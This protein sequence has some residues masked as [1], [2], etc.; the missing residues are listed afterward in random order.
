M[1]DEGHLADELVGA[2]VGQEHA[3]C[4]DPCTTLDDVERIPATGSLG[5]D[6]ASC[7]DG[8]ERPEAV[9]R[10]L[11]RFPWGARNQLGHGVLSR[12]GLLRALC[13]SAVANRL[14]GRP[15]QGPGV[16][17]NRRPVDVHLRLLGRL[18][19]WD[20]TAVRKIGGTKERTLLTLLAL[21][22]GRAV[23]VDAIADAL[24][25]DDPP[26]SA[27]K[28]IPILV[29][30]L[31]KLLAAAPPVPIVI[32]RVG[33]GYR[34]TMP[35]GAVDSALA[36]DL[37]RAAELGAAAGEL[38][39]A[40]QI[41]ARAEK[42]W[43]GASLAD[44]RDLPFAL[45]D[46]QRLDELRVRLLEDRMDVELRRGRPDAVLGELE[47]ACATHPL[48][49]RLWRLRML[50]LHRAG[51]TAEA[52]RSFQAARGV[53]IEE[54]GLEPSEELR[55]LEA[56]I[57]RDDP[58]LRPAEA[59]GPKLPVGE[60]TL[61][62]TDIAGST[63]LWE[64]VPAAMTAALVR[65]DEL[66]EAAVGSRGGVL[67]KARGEGDSSFSVFDDPVRAAAAAVEL[68]RGLTRE[69]WPAKAVLKVR[70]AL[71]TGRAELRGSDY[72]G[73]T[74]NRAARL[75]SAGHGGQILMSE[76]TAALV[77]D[78]LPAQ[79]DVRDLGLRRLK[80]LLNPEHVFQ[81]EHPDLPS[82]FP[83]LA[84]LD[85]RPNNLPVQPTAFV[86]RDA[87][88]ATL[89]C[90]LRDS[91]TRLV[92]L[93]GPGGI[94]K[95][96]LALR[97]A[98]DLIDDFADG[99][100]FVPLAAVVAGE[101]VPAA[102]AAALG[103]RPQ[104]G[105]DLVEALVRH[106]RDR[107]LLLV[108]DNFEQVLAA[109]EL[110]AEL[111]ARCP[112]LTTLVTSR[113]WLHLRAEREVRIDPLDDAS[114]ATLFFD[115]ARAVRI[116]ADDW[117]DPDTVTR[118]CRA[119]DHLPLAIE[120]V[121][122]R[123]RT[124]DQ[125]ELMSQL[126][127]VLDVAS[128]GPR[129]QP[130][131]QRTLRDT[132]RWSVGL[133]IGHERDVVLALSVFRG[134][135]NATA[136][137]AVSGG[138]PDEI[139]TT[140]T[141]LADKSLV[142]QLEAGRYD[143][144]GTIRAYADE[145][146]R[147]Q[148]AALDRTRRAHRRHMARVAQARLDTV[149][150]DERLLEDVV[151]CEPAALA[152]LDNLR[153]ALHLD[154]ADEPAETAA[155]AMWTALLVRPL[156]LAEALDHLEAGLTRVTDDVWA[157]WLGMSRLAV[158]WGLGRWADVEAEAR[159]LLPLAERA[160]PQGSVSIL[161]FVAIAQWRLG[162]HT[163]A[164]A[165]LEQ[166]L[167]LPATEPGW[168][169][170]LLL[171]NRGLVA[172]A[173]GDLRAATTWYEQA[174]TAAAGDAASAQIADLR[175]AQVALERGL[176]AEV[177]DRLPELI[178]SPTAGHV[179]R[180]MAAGA[181]VD[182]L[183]ARGDLSEAIDTAERL[184]LEASGWEPTARVDVGTALAHARLSAGDA[185]G[186][187]AA[188]SDADELAARMSEVDHRRFA[189]HVLGL[190]RA[191]LGDLTGA[192]G[193]LNQAIT[194]M[195]GDGASTVAT[196]LHCDLAVVERVCGDTGGAWRRQVEALERAVDA[197]RVP[198]AADACCY[199]ADSAA[200]RGEVALAACLLGAADSL[201]SEAGIE[202][203]RPRARGEGAIAALAALDEAA[204]NDAAIHSDAG[205]RMALQAVLMLAHQQLP[206]TS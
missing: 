6:G 76:V 54:V 117:L 107:Q 118:I 203:G 133:L 79:A 143:M 66:V 165:T 85:A 2:D 194:V 175:L 43:R 152:D 89:T 29:T 130:A 48:R 177:V 193:A 135:W 8:A 155:L 153:A 80:D 128:D 201:R 49:E 184:W 95:T 73:P 94:G 168:R 102:V 13:G 63:R 171:Q 37:A 64:Q 167:A 62:L 9:E 1:V 40:A 141:S 22:A 121:A 125:D 187:E 78:H 35:T 97:V 91:E 156:D 109:A 20:G 147:G 69:H 42:L 105:H 161:N 157:Y 82:R 53:M 182:A 39:Q 33:D 178:D 31:R 196:R 25:G 10:S 11:L 136:A 158:L 67:L 100:W 160:R 126:A 12:G 4:G 74:V 123:L 206:P 137:S 112:R 163:E 185:A 98:A 108:L 138:D 46:T 180:G 164:D 205:K 86:G 106:L 199:L 103:I 84:T 162:R 99:V 90:L 115:R 17:D 150:L 5:R 26:P 186:A 14:R 77:R 191:H 183:L 104:P 173:R 47:A 146:L 188:A 192:K 38:D 36:E 202:M 122:A 70:I 71:H 21:H 154:G 57:V 181:L 124:F 15:P 45:A 81:L 110:V 139:G 72:F 200:A 87:T 197:G 140:L 169:A 44:V 23:S 93:T 65:H 101:A 52:L 55:D 34:L 51:R 172:E 16:V 151:P 50:A 134:G 190:S 198:A 142:V 145:L 132:I 119:L 41:L 58:S 148:P 111:S 24:W 59:G 83:P 131:R 189:L 204:V 176:A 92:T 195:G 113:E 60:I 120:L 28:G 129:D 3:V 96:R 88:V 30:R 166:A 75:R 159:R 18:E 7:P 144:L 127:V 116:D 61:L 32:D 149:Q 68:Q 170:F 179:T 19:V 56:A 114:A 27:A 174:R